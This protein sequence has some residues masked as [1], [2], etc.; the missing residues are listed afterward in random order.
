[1]KKLPQKVIDILQ[2]IF[3]AFCLVMALAAKIGVGGVMIIL[4]ALLSLPI[5]AVRDV[6]N[7]VL[8]IKPDEE[9]PEMS[10]T[11]WWQVKKKI[12]QKK[13]KTAQE[14]Q[15]EKKLLKVLIIALFFII[16]FCVCMGQISPETT[17]P[18]DETVETS[19]TIDFSESTSEEISDS[20][21]VTTSIHEKNPEETDSESEPSESISEEKAPKAV[22]VSGGSFN[23][24]TIPAFSGK[25]Y[26]V[27]N[28]NIPFFDE[29]DVTTD[30]YEH[31]SN[32]DRLGRC[33]VAVACIGQDLMPTEDRGSIGQVKPTG[34]HTVKYD[35]VDGKYLY[36]RCHLIGY[37]LTAENA[38]TKNLITGTRYLNMDGM[39]PFE[40]MTADYIEE[41]GNHVLYRVTPVFEGN[42]LLATG[43]LMEAM[44]V[45]DEGDGVL[46]NVFCYNAQPGVKI[47]YKNGESSLIGDS[48]KTEPDT[49]KKKQESVSQTSS[50]TIEESE[51]TYILNTSTR[52]FHYPFCS[53]ADDIKASNRRE[54]SGNRS[55]LIAQG[56]SPCKRCNP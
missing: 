24:K 23:I 49:T 30:S 36:N 47:N 44:S 8:G 18:E 28:D 31:Y 6:W 51:D 43:V 32:L 13:I 9:M 40:N 37:Q 5:K 55:A 46:F 27:V 11:Q 20:T 3:V 42:N 52:K 15:K 2:W 39:L 4:V 17:L 7:K 22:T 48:Q 1:M 10:D 34:W 16:S 35:C 19:E 54:F 56:Y 45:E 38:N 12:E 25:P 41:T 14:K 53:S 33:G 26:V 50:T 29:E 21:E